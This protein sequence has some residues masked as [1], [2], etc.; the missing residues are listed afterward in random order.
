[1][2]DD[3]DPRLEAAIND[4]V[5]DIE[6]TDRLAAIREQTRSVG[7]R[8]RGWYAAGGSLLAAAAAVTVIV[9]VTGP[10]ATTGADPAATD[11][12]TTSATATTS[13][14]TSSTATTTEPPHTPHASGD[15]RPVYYVGPGPDGPDAPASVLYPA[16][17][18]GSVLEA[19]LDT[20]RDPDYRTLWPAGSLL[21]ISDLEAEI[22]IVAI[23]ESATERPFGMTDEEAELALQQVAWTVHASVDEP[24]LTVKFSVNDRV[25]DRVLGVDIDFGIQRGPALDVLSHMSISEPAEGST[26][27]GSFTARGLS[28]GFE[29]SVACWLYV[30]N[31]GGAYG[32]WVT[33]A[34]GW[35]E[36]RLFPWELE[37]DL[38]DVPA[39][40]YYLECSTDDP[41]GG[42]EGSGAGVDTRDITVE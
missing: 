20:P 16:Q 9:A 39:G 33:S 19:L 35:Q 5:D 7:A 17:A 41:T 23:A 38:S 14:T 1:M 27:S 10:E 37:I 28:N 25:V 22:V 40:D 29:A 26:Y 13:P 34:E 32:P 6:P 36:P 42:A 8:R 30:G 12:S 24:P 15:A 21:G 2:S 4:A 18:E 3:R 11:P 31:D